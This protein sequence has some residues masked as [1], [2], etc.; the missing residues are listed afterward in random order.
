MKT[1]AEADRTGDDDGANDQDTH[2]FSP[3]LRISDEDYRASGAKYGGISD[4][5][6]TK[7]RRTARWAEDLGCRRVCNFAASAQTFA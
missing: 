7:R 1:A 2:G 4:T 5:V 6:E 3:P